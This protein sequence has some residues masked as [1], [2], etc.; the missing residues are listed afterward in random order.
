METLLEITT[1]MTCLDS[2][3]LIL[4]RQDLSTAMLLRLLARV[5]D[6]END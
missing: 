5:L 6:Y 1:A 2:T 4:G 3:S